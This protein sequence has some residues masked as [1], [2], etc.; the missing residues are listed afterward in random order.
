MPDENTYGFVKN[1]A[2]ALLQ[3][4]DTKEGV[5]S[6]AKTRAYAPLIAVIL[7]AAL[8]D[9]TNSKT[10]PGSCS[11][12]VC[13]WSSTSGEYEETAQQITVSNHSESDS[14]EADTFGYAWN[15]GEK[16]GQAHWVFL[17]DCAPMAAR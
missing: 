8:D 7:D 3:G 10:D 4:I 9:A 1:D 5:Y 17:G 13:E 2:E 14:F 11:A 15:V 6:E 16:D 12:T